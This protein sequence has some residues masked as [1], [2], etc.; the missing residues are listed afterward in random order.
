MP[1]IR[2]QW[3][4]VDPLRRAKALAAVRAAGKHHV[5]SAAAERLH[6]GQ[7]IN[8]VVGGATG[9]VNCQKALPS[10]STWI[11]RAAKNQA[12][13]QIHLR[14]LIKCW[15]DARV[16]RVAGANAP[17]RAGK[18]ASAANKEVAVGG[19]VKCSPYRRIRNTERSLPGESSVC[20][21]VKLPEATWS[22]CTPGLV[23]EPVPHAVCLIDRKPL[24][25]AARGTAL[26]WETRPGLSAIG[27]APHIITKGLE[28]AEIE[29]PSCFIRVQHGV[30]AKHVVF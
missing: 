20:G 24:F 14:A 12:A 10:E 13:A 16:L 15:C 6:A 11:N 19:Y 18:I 5:R 28:K 3:I 23:L 22:G 25:V 26:R 30:A 7:H 27:R 8:V 1:F 21:T 29:E 2:I 9:T 17:E 4:I